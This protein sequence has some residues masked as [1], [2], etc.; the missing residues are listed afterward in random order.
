MT[1]NQ[2]LEDSM[3]AVV[4]VPSESDSSDESVAGENDDI[5]EGEV[6]KVD[7][8]PPMI[9]SEKK[10]GQE[11][12]A[13]E[14]SKIDTMHGNIEGVHGEQNGMESDNFSP[15]A[16]EALNRGGARRFSDSSMGNP[17]NMGSNVKLGQ[18]IEPNSRKR[19]RCMRS[20]LI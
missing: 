6:R 17:F 4:S 9:Q 7:S 10:V 16:V 18:R 11:A 19:R 13:A 5:E 12:A 14:E 20:P 2:I 3:S 1:I 8:V 15:R